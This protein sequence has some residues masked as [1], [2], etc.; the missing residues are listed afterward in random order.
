MPNE[1]GGTEL[2]YIAPEQR[3]KVMLEGAHSAGELNFEISMAI[4]TYTKRMGLTY[5][6]INDVTGAV[7]GAL[8]E[9]QRRV[10]V[11][12]EDSKIESNGDIY[13]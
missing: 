3:T 13:T 4:I 1:E 5:Q 2:P 7:I 8:S 12:Y 6:T 9:Y 10:V 11:P